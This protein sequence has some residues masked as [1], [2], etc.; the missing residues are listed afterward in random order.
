[1]RNPP[2]STILN[3]L[4]ISAFCCNRIS[5]HYATGAMVSRCRREPWLSDP[6]KT[7]AVDHRT[8]DARSPVAFTMRGTQ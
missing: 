6:G 5:G 2:Q 4:E 7:Q 3:R 1:M 8:G